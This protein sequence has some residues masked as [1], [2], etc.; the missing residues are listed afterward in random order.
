MDGLR[1]RQERELLRSKLLRARRACL[2]R[3]QHQWARGRWSKNGTWSG[4]ALPLTIQLTW[5]LIDLDQQLKELDYLPT[6]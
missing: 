1:T 2:F 5:T 6:Y 3:R 4:D